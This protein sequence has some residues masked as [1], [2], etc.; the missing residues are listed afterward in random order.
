MPKIRYVGT[1]PIRT[2]DNNRLVKPGDTLTVTKAQHD[3]L[4]AKF[5]DKTEDRKGKKID[6]PR[7]GEPI[8]PGWEDAE[9]KSVKVSKVP[10]GG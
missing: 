7:A 10:A 4:L 6:H 2:W 3:E 1:A 8:R 5:P 9:P